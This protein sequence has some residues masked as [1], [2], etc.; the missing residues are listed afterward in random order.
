[1]NTTSQVEE[2]PVLDRLRE[3]AAQSPT[4]SLLAE[5]VVALHEHEHSFD[6]RWKADMRAIRRWQQAHPGNDHVWP[7]HADLCVWLMDQ[8]LDQQPSPTP[9]A[10]ARSQGNPDATISDGPPD[11]GE[12]VAPGVDQPRA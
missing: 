7:D 9:G 3:R 6:L 5:A 12:A 8:W 4:D 2:I 10:P 1:M 11:H